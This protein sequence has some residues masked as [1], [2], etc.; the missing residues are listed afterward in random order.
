MNDE[1]L[2]RRATTLRR[3]LTGQLKLNTD[4]NVFDI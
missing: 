3:M 4:M 2:P 1:H